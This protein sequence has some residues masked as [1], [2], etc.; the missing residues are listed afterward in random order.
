MADPSPRD[1]TGA[2]VFVQVMDGTLRDGE[3]TPQLAYTPAEK[4]HIAR[5]LLSE[6]GVDRIEIATTGV[7][8][9]EREA[10][11]R[12]VAWAREAGCLAR[13]EVL[14]FCQG[15]RSAQWLAELGATQLNLLTKGSEA[16]CRRQLGKSPAQHRADVARAVRAAHALG[17]EVGGAYLE[18]WSRG[19][20]DSE[21][22]VLALTEQ[23]LSLGV[24]RIF[25]ADTLGVL[26][27]EQLRRHVRTMRAAFPDAHFELHAHDDYGLA[28][29]NVLTAVAEGVRGVHTSVNGLGERAGNARLHAVVA[30]LHDHSGCR[31]RVDERKLCGVARLVETFSGKLLADNTPVVGRDVFTQ[32]AGVHADGD[33]KG[34]LYL[35]RLSPERF[36]RQRDYALGKLSGQASLAQNLERLGIALS[37][38]EQARL[39]ARIVE[40][41]DRKH[42]VHDGDLPFLINDLLGRSDESRV[43]I[44]DYRVT[45]GKLQEAEAEVEIALDQRRVRARASGSGGYGAFM[46]ALRDAAAQLG[47]QLPALR[48]FRVRIPPGGHERALV[49]AAIQFADATCDPGGGGGTITT[50][51]VDRDQVGAA[52]IATEKM[53]QWLLARGLP[54]AKRPRA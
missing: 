45:V 37:S 36:G 17:I 50:V 24:K 22:Y 3:Q 15:A 5:M 2:P 8:E 54:P 14:G 46:A 27:P 38:G 20:A 31:T 42:P 41:G 34:G 4:L 30:A 25:L 21:C 32:T 29:A 33:R 51:G 40:L 6:V 53:L 23:L 39:L 13:V 52:V 9:G 19:I 10:V 7:S 43:T 12:I 18:D 48:D 26:A 28:T 11:R 44:R 35:T 47:L 16:H 1:P 49:E